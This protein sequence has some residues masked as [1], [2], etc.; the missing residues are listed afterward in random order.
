MKINSLHA[1]LSFL[2]MSS[3]K[4]PHTVSVVDNRAAIMALLEDVR[5]G[6]QVTLPRNPD[7]TYDFVGAGAAAL[8]A[9]GPQ[10]GSGSSTVTTV[11]PSSHISM[12]MGSAKSAKLVVDGPIMAVGT[13]GPNVAVAAGGSSAV[14]VLGGLASSIAKDFAS[15]DVAIS[16]ASASGNAVGVSVCAR[17]M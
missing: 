12:H 7:G 4:K 14:L 6:K 11:D 8:L 9:R 1:S 16:V 2:G 13:S 3:V 10:A 15:G 5:S 17:E